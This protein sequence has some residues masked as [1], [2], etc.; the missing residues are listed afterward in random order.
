[1]CEWALGL[2]GNLLAGQSLQVLGRWL[3][4]QLLSPPA[5]DLRAAGKGFTAYVALL[6]RPRVPGPLH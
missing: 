4:A 5:G 1:M 6:A 2:F 3:G